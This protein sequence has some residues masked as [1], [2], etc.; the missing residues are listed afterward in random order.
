MKVINL[1][2]S[3]SVLNKYMSELRSVNGLGDAGDLMY[4][5]KI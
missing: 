2:D 5:E 4:G 3:N 1:C